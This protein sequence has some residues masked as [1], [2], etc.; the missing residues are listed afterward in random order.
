[1]RS[2]AARLAA[3]VITCLLLCLARVQA[4][5][6]TVY[7]VPDT[8]PD[9]CSVAVD[10][11]VMDWLAT[12][13]DGNTAQFAPDGCYGQDGTI[14]VTART[15]LVID[16]QGSELRALTAG[17]S[18]RANWRFVGGA[19]L[20][21]QNLARCLQPVG[22]RTRGWH[23]CSARRAVGPPETLARAAP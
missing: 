8:I 5:D 10:Q 3:C 4:A 21:V 12:V 23:L 22:R 15:D 9:D 17:D 20:T 2:S 19:N 11:D 14:T 6:A 1:M 13:P 7:Q 18:H 16:G